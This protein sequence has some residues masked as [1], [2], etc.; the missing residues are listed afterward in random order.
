MSDLSD[1]RIQTVLTR[2]I[3]IIDN[4]NNNLKS[5]IPF[6]ISASND[7]K[8]RCLHEL[9]ILLSSLGEDISSDHLEQIRSLHKKLSLN[10]YLL[11]SY[12]SAAR[13]VADLFKRKLQDID[14]DGTYSKG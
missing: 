7:H 8:G 2:V 9:S 11:E 1:Y 5:N 6:D 13:V 12:L 4:E 10:A 3:E 14:A